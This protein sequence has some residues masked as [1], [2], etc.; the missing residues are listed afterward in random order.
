MAQLE[1]VDLTAIQ[2]YQ[3]ISERYEFLSQQVESNR[4]EK[5]LGS[6]LRDGKPDEDFLQF[7]EIANRSFRNFTEMFNG[8]EASLVLQNQ[9]KPRCR[10]GLPL[11]YPGKSTIP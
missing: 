11:N 1:P 9:K 4:G 10:C 2:E 3:Q 7:L 8:G 6:L 5:S